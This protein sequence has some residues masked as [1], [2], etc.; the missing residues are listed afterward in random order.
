M[1]L[2]VEPGVGGADR[3]VR[4]RSQHLHRSRIPVNHFGLQR[5]DCGA[6]MPG[7]SARSQGHRVGV[8]TNVLGSLRRR[9]KIAV[10]R[11]I[12]RVGRRRPKATDGVVWQLSATDCYSSYAWA[13]LIV[14]CNDNAAAKQASKLARQVARE[15][16]Q[17]GWRLERV[18]LRQRQRIQ[19][20]ALPSDSRAT[21]GAHHAHP[22]PL[23]ADERARRSAAPADTRGVLAS[24][25]RPLPL[26]PRHRAQARARALPY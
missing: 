24:G 26:S 3:A 11:R 4:S 18:L 25:P 13:E 20:R 15:L 22:L 14:C 9:R 8:L 10:R 19:E 7:S 12:S 16:K 23:A 1:L 2:G 21:A 17:A 6:A 5:S